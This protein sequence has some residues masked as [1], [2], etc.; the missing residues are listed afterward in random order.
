MFRATSEMAVAITVTSEPPNPSSIAMVRPRWRA[1]TMS[2]A[3]RISTRNSCDLFKF[4]LF[5]RAKFALAL[6]Q[7]GPQTWFNCSFKHRDLLHNCTLTRDSHVN[8]G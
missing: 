6:R 7:R 5:W 4:I 2:A 8:S 1:V 3:E